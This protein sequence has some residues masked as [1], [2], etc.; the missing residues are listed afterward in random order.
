MMKIFTMTPEDKISAKRYLKL[1]AITMVGLALLSMC[2]SCSYFESGAEPEVVQEQSD[3]SPLGV[4]FAEHHPVIFV[5]GNKLVHGL[6]GAF[7][8]SVAL[9]MLAWV[10]KSKSA[11]Q[12]YFGNEDEITAVN[13]NIAQKYP[14]PVQTPALGTVK[15]LWLTF[16]NIPIPEPSVEVVK[17]VEIDANTA[18]IIAAHSHGNSIKKTGLCA[19]Y[20]FG[21]AIIF[22]W[23]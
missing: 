2:V 18:I 11:R 13:W 17:P 20:I 19:A 22:C 9:G 16:R 12:V 1:L 6:A 15:R 14:M 4:M 21:L 8:F 23:G 10:L 5:V 7:L 3:E